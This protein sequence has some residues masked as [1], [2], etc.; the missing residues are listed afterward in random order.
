MKKVLM[1]FL[2]TSI[3][4]SAQ[5]IPIQLLV[6]DA[7]GFE[8]VNTQVKLRL[9]LRNDT[10]STSGQ[11][12]EVHTTSTNAFGIVSVNFGEGIPTSNSKVMG[13]EGFNFSV[14]EPFIKTELD[15]S[16][17]PSNYYSLGWMKYS[18][19][20]VAQRA[21]QAD[22]ADYLRNEIP[23]DDNDS[24]NE[25]QSIFITS[26]GYLKLS[27]VNDSVFMNPELDNLLDGLG[28]KLI[29]NISAELDG[30]KLVYFST[31]KNI[32]VTDSVGSF[33]NRIY[34]AGSGFISD[35][36]SNSS[37]DTLY[38]AYRKSTSWEA[39]IIMMI[40]I[41]NLQAK[42][43][44]SLQSRDLCHVKHNNGKFFSYQKNGSIYELSK[45]GVYN[46]LPGDR[47]LAFTFNQNTLVRAVEPQGSGVVTF[48]TGTSG[49]SVLAGNDP[50][51]LEYANQE[52]R[53]YIRYPGNI[54]YYENGSESSLI[55]FTEGE[56]Q[57][58]KNHNYILSY[59]DGILFYNI[60]HS[61]YSIKSDGTE[62]KF[63]SSPLDGDLINGIVISD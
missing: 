5:S 45:D 24:T 39:P 6:V 31:S 61:I 56:Y 36:S 40:P 53:L 51:D 16:I 9:T 32:Y 8:K 23:N 52:N 47:V 57:Y 15:T 43:K 63:I 55:N 33:L 62:N 59:N 2:F 20:I 3:V 21:L 54:S 34:K 1:I 22:T 17:S 46:A 25:L 7:N 49:G 60:G 26:K 50:K 27:K 42:V 58:I 28:G 11:Y 4:V 44:G 29:E 30:Q 38:F 13:L 41:N 18:Y 35:L 10:S 19:P 12:T 14:N 37:G 48:T